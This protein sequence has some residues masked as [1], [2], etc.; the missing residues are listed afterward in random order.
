MLFT[1][2]FFFF[3]CCH[4]QIPRDL[5][6]SRFAT[7]NGIEMR[8]NRIIWTRITAQYNRAM[9]ADKS[10]R[11]PTWRKTSS[12]SLVI[13]KN[14]SLNRVL[15]YAHK[16]KLTARWKCDLVALHSQFIAINIA[17]VSIL[18]PIFIFS[19]ASA[20][21]FSRKVKKIL[22]LVYSWFNWVEY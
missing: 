11:I 15:N 13:P 18:V 6:A 1:Y 19:L 2:L 14:K 4:S 3:C 16:C 5:C 10:N 12:V 20:F 17:P 21:F 8:T 22:N 9:I 7:N